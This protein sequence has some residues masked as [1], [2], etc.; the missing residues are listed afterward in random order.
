MRALHPFSLVTE[1][2]DK[3]FSTSWQ[4]SRRSGYSKVASTVSQS[5]VTSH[6][7][8]VAQT[9]P[10]VEDKIGSSRKGQPQSQAD[11]M[12]SALPLIRHLRLDGKV[13]QTSEES[14]IYKEVRPYRTLHPAARPSHLVAGSLFTAE[15]LPS[16]PYFFIPSLQGTQQKSLQDRR[17][18]AT[19]YVGP[20]LCGHAG[21]VH[22]GLPFLL[23][24]DVFACCAG[25][26]F[27]SGVAMTAKMNIDFLKPAIP[28]RVYVYRAEITKTEGRKAWVRG[29]M[30]CINAFTVDEMRAR[31]M[32]MSDALSTEEKESVL[33]AEAAALFVE[34][35]FGKASSHTTLLTLADMADLDFSRWDLFF[36]VVVNAIC[37]VRIVGF[38]ACRPIACRLH[39]KSIIFPPTSSPSP[40]RS[41]A[42]WGTDPSSSSSHPSPS[43]SGSGT[44]W[45]AR[46][47]D[48]TSSSSPSSP[49]LGRSGANC[50]SKSLAN[51]GKRVSSMTFLRTTPSG[52]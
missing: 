24:D 46:T 52:V 41:G 25:M 2:S 45:A 38:Q 44:S 12:I 22:G 27:E 35:R 42:N 21:Y 13:S 31:Q 18:I 6:P 15:K 50:A 3:K 29:Q 37:E 10:P 32:P 9:A 39:R 14:P 36:L 48:P 11:D 33:V 34:P 17:V 7:S 8:P 19:C 28:N 51:P 43:L 30:R 23:F 16:D 47:S 49:S 40:G 20:Y 1:V 4:P 5:S 26:L